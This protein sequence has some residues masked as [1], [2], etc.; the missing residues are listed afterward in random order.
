MAAWLAPGPC[1]TQTYHVHSSLDALET[2]LFFLCQCAPG[3][4]SVPEKGGYSWCFLFRF[5]LLSP[6]LPFADV[7]HLPKTCWPAW[8]IQTLEGTFDR[9]VTALEICWV[10]CQC[11]VIWVHSMH[12]NIFSSLLCLDALHSVNNLTQLF[13]VRLDQQFQLVPTSRLPS[14]KVVAIG[15]GPQWVN[16]SN[17]F[18]MTVL[19]M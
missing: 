4:N 17:L 5:R 11:K 8:A 15:P 13:P 19:S 14:A 2:E 6:C 7:L 9:M 3:V 10:F 18:S 16:Y 1:E 12:Y